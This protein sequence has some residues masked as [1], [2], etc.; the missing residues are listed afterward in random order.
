MTKLPS[1]RL[2]YDNC[3]ETTDGR[4]RIE[5]GPAV[6]T[7]E[8]EWHLTDLWHLRVSGTFSTKREA[9]EAIATIDLHGNL[10]GWDLPD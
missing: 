3:Y 6:L 5:Y 9:L 2:I 1:T 4:F 10:R 7:N 8:P